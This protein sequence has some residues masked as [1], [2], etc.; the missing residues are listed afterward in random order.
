MALLSWALLL[1][2]PQLKFVTQIVKIVAPKLCRSFGLPIIPAMIPI[3]FRRLGPL[4]FVLIIA[5]PLAGQ[6]MEGEASFY[7]DRFH[8]KSTSTGEKHDKNG[9]MA[10]SKEFDYG[11]VLEVTNITT[12][13]RVR[14]RVNDC[15]PH[16][17]DRIIDLS[18]AAAQKIGIV[19]AGVAMVRLRVVRASNDGPTCF[20]S[21]WA[22]EQKKLKEAESV[23][24]SSGGVAV[25]E[26]AP[27]AP[28]LPTVGAA[29]DAPAPE[30]YATPPTATVPPAAPP[31]KKVFAPDEIVFGVQVGAFGK[32]DNADRLVATLAAAG[33]GDAWAVKVGRI[34]RVF[35]GQFYFSNQAQEHKKKVRSAGY[36]EA[37]V[38][39]IQ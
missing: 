27:V 2:F 33:F 8:G 1:Y 6:R 9:Y 32:K 25:L 26:N 15:G 5:L 20:R 21:A 4:F 31:M 3:T 10:A 7:A 37:T 30:S 22:K 17:P 36:P 34:Y 16:H 19:K 38:R 35:T 39:R 14:V 18:R 28:P 12:G 11:T 13:E 24:A 23:V 29:A